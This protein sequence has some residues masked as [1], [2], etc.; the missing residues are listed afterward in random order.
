MSESLPELQSPRTRRHQESIDAAAKAAARAGFSEETFRDSVLGVRDD[1]DGYSRALHTVEMRKVHLRTE[2][3]PGKSREQKA[4]PSPDGVGPWAVDVLTLA[5]TTRVVAWCPACLGSGATKCPAC[6]G[7]AKLR[8]ARCEG[9]GVDAR[10]AECPGCGGAKKTPCDACKGGQVEC[11]GCRGTGEVTAW[12][13]VERSTRPVVSVHPMGAAA[14][15]HPRVSDPADFDLDPS[16]WAA[17]RTEDTGVRAPDDAPR[18]LAPAQL[19]ASER[20]VSTRVQRFQT[21]RCLVTY[22]TA[23]ATGVVPVS[24]SAPEVDATADWRPIELRRNVVLVVGAAALG[25]GLFLASGW[26]SRHAWYAQS[27]HLPAVAALAAA[28]ALA[29]TLTVSGLLLHGQARTVTRV[30]VPA[31]ALMLLTGAIALLTSRD[32]PRPAH[33][34]ASLDAGDVARAALEADA[35][36]ALDLD[37]DRAAGEAILDQV[38]LRA[39]TRAASPEAMAVSA[40][41]PWYQASVR[42]EAQRAV[43][44]AIERAAAG[45]DEARVTALADLAREFAPP[46]RERLLREGSLRRAGAC[47]EAGEGRCVRDETTR[48][49]VH[50]A[51][52]AQTDPLLRRGRERCAESLRA[53]VTSADTARAAEEQAARLRPAVARSEGC[54]ALTQ[55]PTAP[56]VE[57]LRERLR[58]AESRIIAEVR[59]EG[60]G[61]AP[62]AEAPRRRRHRGH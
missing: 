31:G 62:A 39:L 27:G 15:A 50:G 52:P 18:E 9:S 24:G 42:E 32:R 60:A 38:H 3:G 11:G 4:L 47:A 61:A 58:S 13:E 1:V 51:E 35:L 5:A 6:R 28:L 34:R 22:G 12:L 21:V 17:T 14:R 46:L 7:A 30:W 10:G 19:K 57:A 2:P 44:A 45:A 33:A 23:L 54:T 55:E 26:A 36:R 16:R 8:C 40:R 56:T 49:L 20:A 53:L 41:A 48:A 37:L 43:V 25:V 29:F 59:P